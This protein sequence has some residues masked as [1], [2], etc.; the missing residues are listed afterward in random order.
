LFGVTNCRYDVVVVQ[1]L[2]KML[3]V[4]KL[5]APSCAATAATA[6]ATGKSTTSAGKAS[7]S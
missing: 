7:A 3:W 6:S 4:H 2:G 1:M 5:P